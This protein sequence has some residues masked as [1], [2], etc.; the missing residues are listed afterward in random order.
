MNRPTKISFFLLVLG[1][2]AALI[3]AITLKDSNILSL[4]PPDGTTPDAVGREFWLHLSAYSAWVCTILLLPVFFFIWFPKYAPQWRAFWFASFAAYIIHLAI[5]MFGFFGGDFAWMTNSTR[6]SAF[7][8][9][10]LLVLWWGFDVALANRTRILI[11]IQRI[12]VHL[13]AFVLFFGGSALKG[14]TL[15]IRLIGI[16]LLLVA[17]SAAMQYVMKR[18][19]HQI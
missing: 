19:G 4:T 6:V 18:R 14:E 12:G 2:A 3:A 16:L 5:S 13:L 15:T 11:Q 7:W 8:P 17:I 9:G 10:M 1:M